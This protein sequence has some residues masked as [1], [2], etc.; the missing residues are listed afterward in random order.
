MR[1][2][3]QVHLQIPCYDFYLLH[4][5]KFADL[6]NDTRANTSIPPVNSLDDASEIAT[7]GV[8]KGQGRNRWTLVTP[9]Y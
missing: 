4:S 5:K 9:V 8:Y 3:L 1:I 6:G 7:G 2:H